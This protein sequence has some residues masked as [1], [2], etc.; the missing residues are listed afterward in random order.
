VTP[1]A[2]GEVP[3]VKAARRVSA[4]RDGEL[5]RF[6]ALPAS[7]PLARETEDTV[8]RIRDRLAPYAVGGPAA[9]KLD[10]DD[11]FARDG[12]VIFPAVL[13]VIA[14]ILVALLRAIVAPLYLVGTVVVSFACALGLSV[15]T[16]D[17][18]IG[19]DGV[20]PALPTFAF[21]FL[22]ALGVDYNLFLMSRAREEV[23]AHGAR[24]GALRGLTATGGV[25][26]SAGLVLAGT[27]AALMVLPLDTL[28]QIGFT[29]ALGLLIDALIVRTLLV[30]SLAVKL[31]PL[32]WLPSRAEP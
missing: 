6:E 29:V 11:A 8:E 10:G 25:I 7:A 3:G 12:R 13:A 1:D 26:T 19:M 31:G 28:F 18:I 2:L 27:F 14:L 30:P 20:S 5:V 4:S 23:A 22:V 32:S 16:F 9:E 15:L 21:V 17:K 24:E